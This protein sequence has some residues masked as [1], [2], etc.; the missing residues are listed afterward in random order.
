MA[1]NLSKC[2][3][4]ARHVAEAFT[5]L[6]GAERTTGHV[7][8][9]DSGKIGAA[10]SLGVLTGQKRAPTSPQSANQA[11]VGR[12]AATA[13]KGGSAIIESVADNLLNLR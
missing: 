6:A 1:G 8:T 2:E 4:A 11:I 9:V 5:Y 3:V 10:L 13:S 7:M 12:I